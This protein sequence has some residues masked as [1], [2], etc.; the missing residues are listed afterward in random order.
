MLPLAVALAQ[1]ARSF[2]RDVRNNLSSTL[3][4]VLK[5][6]AVNFIASVVLFAPFTFQ[7]S[8]VERG[9]DVVAQTHQNIKQLG[10]DL[11]NTDADHT[12]TLTENE[13]AT[14]VSSNAARQWLAGATFE[15]HT[16]LT[17]VYTPKG[18]GTRTGMV[19]TIHLANGK[20]CKAHDWFNS[21]TGDLS[22][23][24]YMACT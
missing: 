11:I 20:T 23:K 16:E 14:V 13:V 9:M 18:A 3:R 8:V 7:M 1:S 10:L 5:P 4:Y 17:N 6:A 21:R 15:V 19:T 12:R 2:R 22:P 24:P